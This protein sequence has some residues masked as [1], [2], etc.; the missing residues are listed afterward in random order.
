MLVKNGSYKNKERETFG[1]STPRD[2]SK[3][4][5]NEYRKPPKPTPRKGSEL[6]AIC[7][8]ISFFYTCWYFGDTK[9][10]GSLFLYEPL[11]LGDKV[12]PFL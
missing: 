9:L 10:S 2:T 7:F 8:V 12:T 5:L 1:N 4:A 11:F 6:A 3:K